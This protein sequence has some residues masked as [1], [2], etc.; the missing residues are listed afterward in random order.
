MTISPLL[1][2]RQISRLL[3]I[4][5]VV[6]LLA[7]CTYDPFPAPDMPK[8]YQTLN[9]PLTEISL[10]VS[11]LVD[12]TNFIFGDSSADMIYFKFGGL[13]DTVT[14]TED[15]FVIPATDP[16]SLRQDFSQISM[17]NNPI[18]ISISQQVTLSQ[19]FGLPLPQNEDI[20]LPSIE[21]TKSPESESSFQIFDPY[22]IP[23]F[24]RVD[25]IT[26]GSGT[27]STEIE[28]QLPVDLDSVKLQLMNREGEII[29]T[30]FYESIPSGQTRS[31]RNPGNLDG[32]R[33]QD[34]IR[35]VYTAIIAGSNGQPV[36][37]L[38]GTDPYV[39]I[40]ARFE[41]EEIES[42]TGIPKPIEITQS[43]AIPPSNNTVIR[44]FI[45][46]TTT[47]TLDTN[48]IALSLNNQTPLNIGMR[49]DF[50]NFYGETGVLSVDT[51]MNAQRSG[52]TYERFDLDTLRNTD[53]VS[54]V[55]SFTVSTQI[56]LLPDPGDTVVTIPLNMT[57]A[58]YMDVSIGIS[59]IKFNQIDGF[60]NETFT[61]PP[62]TI[63]DI[64]TGFGDVDFDQVLLN[65]TFFNE[66]QAQTNLSFDIQGFR[67][68]MNPELV[69]A[70]GE[71]L[72]ATD[73]KPVA[74]SELN[75]DIAP[76]FNMLPDSIIVSGEAAIP[77]S[78]TSKLQVNKSFWGEYEVVVPFRLK[79]NPM[80]FIPV[81][82]N[83]MSPMDEQTRD[84]IRSGLIE[85]SILTDVENDFPMTGSLEILVSNYDYFPLSIDSLDSGY[86]MI[87]DSLFTM[88]DTGLVCIEYDT[89]MRIDLPTPL[90]MDDEGRVVIPGYRRHTAEL[91]SARLEFLMSDQTHYI[92][93]RIHL[94][95][96]EDFVTVGYYDK[97]SVL[98]LI[99]LTIDAGELLSE[100]EEDSVAK[101]IVQS[102][103]L[104]KRK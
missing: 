34:S 62:M 3:A 2:Y 12:T 14:L 11:S 87:N 96:T 50:N 24:E 101:P 52:T 60:F 38:A 42:C 41:V 54:I 97:V 102:K 73:Q 39:R 1:N 86:Y 81:K 27:F 44:G 25:Y 99:S 79:M 82:S 104:S 10:E 71:I 35:V 33:L 48:V 98:S 18:D 21:R 55:D 80:T 15:I 103:Q 7:G 72:K 56:L 92:R 95:G 13:L 17:A 64:P 75:I 85:A 46:Q 6:C 26:I 37:I 70:D 68:G 53:G 57:A 65:L 76:V 90:K 45:G 100:D 78:D 91:D 9:L 28:N 84:Q 22:G 19:Q 74:K 16:V 47:G 77:A 40:G 88:S 49:I 20:I 8:F 36:M 58:D 89:L 31:D 94:N 83:K 59:A 5:I 69:S 63:R 29:V 30:S 23:Y 43:Q 51:V 4:I 61:I 32:K 66:I 93:A 67:A